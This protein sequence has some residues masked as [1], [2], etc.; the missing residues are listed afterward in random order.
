M[1]I[2]T[3]VAVVELNSGVYVFVIV[4]GRGVDR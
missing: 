4:V 1:E 2:L 3:E